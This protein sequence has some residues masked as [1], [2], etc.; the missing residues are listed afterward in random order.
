MFMA[1]FDK[2]GATQI[3]TR[4]ES[5]EE[6]EIDVDEE[7]PTTSRASRGGGSKKTQKATVN[8]RY[9]LTKPILSAFGEKAMSYCR[10]PPRPTFMLGSL[11]KDLIVTHKK[12][13][14][15][16]RA[17]DR[18]D[19]EAKRTKIRELD[20][21]S[22]ENEANSTVSEIERV[23]KCLKRAYKKLN[24]S[25]IYSTIYYKFRLLYVFSFFRKSYMSL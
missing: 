2:R 23:F 18:D 7:M 24:G 15:Q 5:D 1:N 17:A 20:A 10:L 8:D 22:N 9:V 11:D 21:E 25:K 14:Q 6:E 13:R 4:Q 3:K 19:V 12:V 16:R